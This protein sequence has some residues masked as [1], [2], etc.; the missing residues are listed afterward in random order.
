MSQR[1]SGMHEFLIARFPSLTQWAASFLPAEM[2]VGI[3][4]LYQLIN[5]GMK[6]FSRTS[7]DGCAVGKAGRL[8]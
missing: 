8:F 3:R 4:M 1:G 5:V 7:F 6:V 2:H